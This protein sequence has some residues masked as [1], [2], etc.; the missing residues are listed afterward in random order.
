MSCKI[1]I[2]GLGAFE[3]GHIARIDSRNNSII[4]ETRI[5]SEP[6]I[7]CRGCY[8]LVIAFTTNEEFTTYACG[9]ISNKIT[10]GNCS[11]LAENSC[12]SLPTSGILSLA[13]RCDSRLLASGGKDGKLS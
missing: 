10:I 13:I 2:I 9:G 12:I 4:E 1:S 6:C 5:S 8:F 11:S 7:F 3:S